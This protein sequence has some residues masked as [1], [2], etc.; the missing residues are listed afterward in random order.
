MAAEKGRK[1]EKEEKIYTPQEEFLNAFSHAIGAIFAIYALIMLVTTSKTPLQTGTTA[2]YGASLFL[3]FEAS[4]CYHAIT[5]ETAKKVFRKIDHSAIYLLIAGTYTPMLMLVLEIPYSIIFLVMIWY[6]ALT[7]VVFSCL[8]LKFKR[9]STGLYVLMG[10]LSVFL[11]Y[12][13]WSKGLKT[14]MFYLVS[15]GVVYTAGSYFYL[16]KRKYFH[17][18]WHFFVLFGAILHYFAIVSLL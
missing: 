4:T 18:I 17:G 3:L 5:G 15:G 1:M 8:T 12:I 10:W 16:S 14:T 7:G 2:I 6:L 13:L 9:L 11:L